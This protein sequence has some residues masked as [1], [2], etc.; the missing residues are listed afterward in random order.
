MLLCFWP[1]GEAA[2]PDASHPGK[3]RESSE[4]ESF[5]STSDVPGLFGPEALKLFVTPAPQVELVFL[6]QQR[7]I[8]SCGSRGIIPLVGSGVKPQRFLPAGFNTKSRLKA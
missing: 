4:G 1:G 2:N 6:S 3:A 5:L 7:K 8:A